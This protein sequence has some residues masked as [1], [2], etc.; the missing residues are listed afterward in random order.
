MRTILTT[1]ALA[2]GMSLMAQD[3]S[4]GKDKKTP[5]ER[6]AKRT[7]QMTKDLGLSSEQVAK[8]NTINLN[9]ARYSSDVEAAGKGADVEGRTKALK[10][11]RD[12]E[13][14]A[15]LTPEQYT[16]YEEIRAK[17]Q[18]DKKSKDAGN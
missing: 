13:L 6:A 17:K 5:E 3:A 14:K 15:V 4:A 9:F 18:A 12:A 8:V 16:K 1:L 2:V 7:E 11:K 10:A